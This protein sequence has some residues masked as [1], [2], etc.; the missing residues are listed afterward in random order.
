MVVE[1]GT[2]SKEFAADL[3]REVAHARGRGIVSSRATRAS[4]ERFV[5]RGGGGAAA[6]SVRFSQ[7]RGETSR[8]KKSFLT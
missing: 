5:T 6:F 3:T 7:V 1:V 2:A 8:R 4:C